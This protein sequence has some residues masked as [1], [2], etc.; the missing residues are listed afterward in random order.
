M[1]EEDK[2]GYKKN[3]MAYMNVILNIPTLAACFVMLF[4]KIKFIFAKLMRHKNV[5]LFV[6]FMFWGVE[7][8]ASIPA[9]VIHNYHTSDP[10]FTWL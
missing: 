3:E 4:F 2:K 6:L 10:E 1:N 8:M 9:T 7:V 5:T